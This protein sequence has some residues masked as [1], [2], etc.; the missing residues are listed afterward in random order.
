M[1]VRCDSLVWCSLV[2]GKGVVVVPQILVTESCLKP[3]S[4]SWCLVEAEDLAIGSENLTTNRPDP[5]PLIRE[6][7][8][9]GLAG[10]TGCSVPADFSDAVSTALDTLE[11]PVS[12][13]TRT[14]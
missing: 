13:G 10:I 11:E 14:R 8:H 3:W 12:L 1:W 5:F 9:P 7:D 2:E 4:P 6:D